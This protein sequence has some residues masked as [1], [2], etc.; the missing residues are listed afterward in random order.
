MMKHA[1]QAKAW[2]ARG[3][4]ALFCLAASPVFLTV[5]AT[6]ALADLKICNKTESRI[7]V[8]IGYKDDQGWATEG[9][10]N[11]SGNA[12]ETLLRG[13]LV[14]RYYYVYAIDY[15]AGGEWNGNAFMCT[16]DRMF[17]IRGINNCVERGYDRT[18]FLEIDTGDERE[19]T[20]QLLE[21][22]ATEGSTE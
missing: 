18:G 21:P 13:A 12:C 15:D 20:V 19:W 22:G 16:Q 17:T 9:W 4:A 11:I 7:G 1:A 6:P 14:A 10:W 5:S 2:F 8:A 3:L